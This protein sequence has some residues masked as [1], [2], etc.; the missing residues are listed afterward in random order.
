MSEDTLLSQLDR[1]WGLGQADQGSSPSSAA[2]C[3]V[4]LDILLS[5]AG[6]ELF[7]EKN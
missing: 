1:V 6:P 3:L 4:S 5:L 7:S 2:Y